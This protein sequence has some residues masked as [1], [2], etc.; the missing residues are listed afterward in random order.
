M[1]VYYIGL[2]SGT[3][4]DAIDAA[5]V[6]FDN[7]KIKFHSALNYPIPEELRQQVLALISQ[8]E[9]ELVRM[10]QLDVKLGQMFAEAV[11][12]LLKHAN[13]P[14]E[15]VK[16]IGSHGQTLRHF[17][18]SETPGTLQIGDPNIIAE[19]TGIT[20]VAD[21]RRRDMAAGGQG[22]P[23]VPAFHQSILQDKEINRI[24]LN[25]GGIANITVLAKDL[26]KSVIGFD[27][28]PGNALMDS[29][30]QQHTQQTQQTQQTYDKDG[31]WAASG[32]INQ[33]LLDILL[34]DPYFML[35]PPKSTGRETFNMLWLNQHLQNFAAL[36]EED[37]Q[38][39]LTEFTAVTIAQA[40][41]KYA[42]ETEQVLV[43]GGGV[44]NRY[45]MQ[46]L[47]EHLPEQLIQS[48]KV[49]GLDPDWVEAMAFAWQAKQT[50]EG[51]TGNL[52]SVTGA[53]HPAI[54]GGIF[55]GIPPQ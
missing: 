45:L 11:L 35:P 31:A 24:T 43:C 39:T 34:A 37:I 32:N 22:A 40:I 53:R 47:A 54:L 49:V 26:D 33:Q 23:L 14:T 12:A 16:A 41:L 19:T 8:G 55:G 10:N 27:T 17:P 5:L 7:N 9:N 51:L 6:S 46:R 42:A 38:A 29:W 21:F 18:N 15:Q 48:S 2:M 4:V 13:I 3:S 44:H 1:S 28:G 30:I 20:T 50:L 36:S 52:P 25:I